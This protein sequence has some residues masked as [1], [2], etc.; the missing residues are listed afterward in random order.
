MKR[1]EDFERAF[2]EMSRGKAEA[3]IVPQMSLFVRNEKMVADGAIK[4]RLPLY[5]T[6]QFTRAGGLPS[7]NSD[8]LENYRRAAV[9]VDK[10]FKGMKP[11]DIPV[12]EPERFKLVINLRTA[13]ALGIT[14][15][16]SLLIR[17]DE[18]IE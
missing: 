2:A 14:I 15:L 11:A 18:V 17:A 3:L 4:A 16:Q 13:K 8:V 5:S 12:E 10:I 6:G 1:P 9:M 7:F